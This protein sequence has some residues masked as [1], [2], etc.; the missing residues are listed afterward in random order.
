MCFIS[1]P[2]SLRMTWRPVGY[3]RRRPHRCLLS[4]SICACSTWPAGQINRELNAN[5]HALMKNRG[6]DSGEIKTVPAQGTTTWST[7]HGSRGHTSQGQIGQTQLW[8]RTPV[9]LLTDADIVA[10]KWKRSTATSN[11]TAIRRWKIN[12]E[13]RFTL[14]YSSAA[15][16]DKSTHVLVLNTFR[17]SHS[18]SLQS[19]LF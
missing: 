17:F 10:A 16:G 7:V 8:Q 1:Q 11:R 5:N 15:T 12:V 3:Q 18:D 19:E 6:G 13:M 9:S 4:S 14:L 2:A